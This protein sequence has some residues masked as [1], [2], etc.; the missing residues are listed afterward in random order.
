MQPQSDPTTEVPPTAPSA[1]RP[2]PRQRLLLAV[3][4]AGGA[5]LVLLLLADFLP[6]LV[7]LGC[8]AFLVGGVWVGR[9]SRRPWADG[10]IY[11][12]LSTL[13]AA[14]LLA[15]ISPMGW[16]GLLA[17]PFLALPQGILGVWLGAR[18]FQHQDAAAEEHQDGA[19]KD[20]PNEE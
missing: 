6:A 10:A 20:R 15:I 1:K 2:T 12:G 11:G 14:V 17:A 19:V 9:Y 7:Y 18:I 3:L 8:L 13:I 16:I 5:F 4:Y